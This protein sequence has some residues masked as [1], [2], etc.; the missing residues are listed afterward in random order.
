MKYTVICL[1]LCA[2]VFAGCQK[3]S[4]TSPPKTDIR[5]EIAGTW[6]YQAYDVKYYDQQNIFFYDAV[7]STNTLGNYAPV[8]FFDNGSFY[9]Q[10]YQT[11]NRPYQIKM[12]GGI[13]SLIL[14]GAINGGSRFHIVS[15]TKDQMR[16]ESNGG[17]GIV[18][19]NQ[20]QYANYKRSHSTSVLVKK[21]L[22]NIY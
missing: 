2:V 11:D 5:A 4:R 3:E 18:F 8:Q 7:A 1:A 10:G 17:A 6:Y 14:E 12:T 22:V 20:S 15:I 16:L 19:N 13:D 9:Y 21:P